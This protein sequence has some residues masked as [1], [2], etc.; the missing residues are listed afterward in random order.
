MGAPSAPLPAESHAPEEFENNGQRIRSKHRRT[1][2]D[3]KWIRR[4][5]PISD[6]ARALDLKGEG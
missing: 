1:V 4:E 5:I 3:A 2:P 6:V